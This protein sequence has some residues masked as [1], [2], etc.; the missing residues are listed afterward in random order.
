MNRAM[1]GDQGRE[2]WFASLVPL[3]FF[4]ASFAPAFLKACSH[5][6]STML[7]TNMMTI[8]HDHYRLLDFVDLL[9]LSS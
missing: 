4:S 6:L 5:G 9:R 2:S 3:G 8:L 1:L 7:I